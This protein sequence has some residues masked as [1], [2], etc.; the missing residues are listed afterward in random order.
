MKTWYLFFWLGMFTS[1]FAQ[2]PLPSQ[3]PASLYD[4]LLEINGEWAKYPVPETWKNAPVRFDDDIA[5]IQR[6]LQLVSSILEQ[7]MTTHLSA[8][9]ASH[10]ARLLAALK[11][12]HEAGR[13]PINTRH[14]HRIPYFIDDYGTA[15]AVGHLLIQSGQESFARQIR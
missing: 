8:T 4:H 10:R 12:Y 11:A 1:L 3:Q 9:Q 5:R 2:N 15:C 13:F 14:N 7:R 6:H